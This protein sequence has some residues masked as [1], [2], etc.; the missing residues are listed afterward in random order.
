MCTYGT[1][2]PF[3]VSSATGN[4]AVLRNASKDENR[5]YS[6]RPRR[7]SGKAP[8]P[9]ELSGQDANFT[10]RVQSSSVV[11]KRGDGSGGGGGCH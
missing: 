9:V 4:E 6:G 1:K 10:L 11:S 8:A 7:N 5:D 3:S 2:V